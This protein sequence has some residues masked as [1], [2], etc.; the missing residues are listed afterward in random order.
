MRRHLMHKKRFGEL[1]GGRR[2]A[3]RAPGAAGADDGEVYS[4]TLGKNRGGDEG[5]EE[6]GEGE[7]AGSRLS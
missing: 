3:A 4:A 5:N 7:G 2:V 6:E 1:G